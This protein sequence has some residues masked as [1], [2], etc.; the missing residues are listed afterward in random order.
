MAFDEV[1]F[2]RVDSCIGIGATKSA[3]L[4]LDIRGG[5]SFALA[6]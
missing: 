6:V 5:D 2:N 1:Y 3:N 4:A